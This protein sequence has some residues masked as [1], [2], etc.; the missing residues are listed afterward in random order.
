MIEDPAAYGGPE[1][2]ERTLGNMEANV[3]YVPGFRRAHARGV[4]FRGHFTATPE[5]AKLTIAE[6]MQGDEIPVTVRLLKRRRQPV[7]E[8]PQRRPRPGRA[9]R[10]AVRRHR[11]SG[12]R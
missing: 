6:H 1:R 4:G 12:P 8:G 3:G 10:A 2:V 11:R 5:V 9:L 7:R